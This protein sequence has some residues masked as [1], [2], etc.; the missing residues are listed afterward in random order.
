MSSLLVKSLHKPSQ[1]LSNHVRMRGIEIV[2]T[3]VDDIEFRMLGAFE[4]LD[5]F[6]G[7]L[8][9]EGHVSR[10]LEV[11][12]LAFPLAH[13]ETSTWRW[14]GPYMQPKDR[15]SNILQPTMQ[16][17][18]LEDVDDG[19]AQ[20]LPAVVA[21][22]VP[23][24][25]LPPVDFG[26]LRTVRPEPEI[27]DQIAEVVFDH[28]VG[29]GLPSGGAPSIDELHVRGVRIVGAEVARA[30]RFRIHGRAQR[31]D[32]L[33]L[34]EDTFLD[35]LFFRVSRKTLLASEDD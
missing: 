23:L 35:Q 22:V 8:V 5:L 26:L 2:P 17:V 34:L 11:N 33:H 10:S 12:R 13:R 6:L 7:D 24:L 15:T 28:P 21:A 30:L 3:S 9:G 32:A 29:R 4:Q 1:F 19:C 25:D 14:N 18:S 27:P 20:P 31:N 16:P